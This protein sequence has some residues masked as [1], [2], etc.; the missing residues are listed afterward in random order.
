MIEHPLL[1][2]LATGGVIVIWDII[3]AVIQTWWLDRRIK[4]NQICPICKK[5]EEESDGSNAGN[6]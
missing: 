6:D 3:R 1:Y 2:G 4:Q 5:R